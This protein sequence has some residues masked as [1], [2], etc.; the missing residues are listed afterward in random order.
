MGLNDQIENVPETNYRKELHIDLPE[1]S[2]LIPFY[3]IRM[4]GS[5]DK[6]YKMFL[7]S[8]VLYFV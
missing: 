4:D 8:S 2:A 3:Q 1:L 5:F 6:C 7:F